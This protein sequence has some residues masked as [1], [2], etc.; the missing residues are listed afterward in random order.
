[1]IISKLQQFIIFDCDQS[2]ITIPDSLKDK[3]SKITKINPPTGSSLVIWSDV[4]PVQQLNTFTPNTIY[5]ITSKE[6]QLGYELAGA[7]D[8]ATYC[9]ANELPINIQLTAINPNIELGYPC[10]PLVQCPPGSEQFGIPD[11]CGESNKIEYYASYGLFSYQAVSKNSVLSF[12]K[13]SGDITSEPIIFKLKHNSNYYGLVTMNT[14][15][16]VGTSFQ[17]VDGCTKYSG[18]FIPGDVVM[19]AQT[20]C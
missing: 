3:V 13:S 5:L 10:I 9:L 12:I 2:E 16:Y 11:C 20:I 17:I 15:R 19:S 4:A 7:V 6:G 14:S 8:P 18:V 1:M